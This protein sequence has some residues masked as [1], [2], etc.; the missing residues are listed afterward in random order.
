MYRR[1][2]DHGWSADPLEFGYAYQ[3]LHDAEA[4]AT[5]PAIATRV[6]AIA[7][8]IDYLRLLYEYNNAPAAMKDAALDVLLTHV[9]RLAP[10]GMVHAYRIW[11]LLYRNASA[12]MQ[13]RW[14][15]GSPTSH[16]A[17]WDQV[18][19]MG[20]ITS[21][22]MHEQV[23]AG[24][25]AYPSLGLSPASSPFVGPLVPLQ[26]PPPST[27]VDTTD[28]G[29]SNEYADEYVFYPTAGTQLTFTVEIT[30]RGYPIPNSGAHIT[31]PGGT[32][33]LTQH[34]AVPTNG[35]MMYPINFTP[36]QTGAYHRRYDAAYVEDHIVHYPQSL[37]FVHVLP[38]QFSW[39]VDFRKDYF[40]VPRGTA[41]FGFLTTSTI[42]PL[43]QLP[44]GTQ[45][46][47][48]WHGPIA[49]IDVPPGQDH[50]VWSITGYN[51][52]MEFENIPNYVAYR[53]EQLLVPSDSL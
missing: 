27:M 24:V 2:W 14:D 26:T 10:T 48:A 49:V 6:T 22:E 9:W 50:A 47:V 31:D 53:P 38:D 33:V 51:G 20:P 23:E 32:I 29:Y 34:F 12:A 11:Q 7:G 30:G 8:Y 42:Q 46:T 37:P 5:D 18:T 36:S 40:W 28:M 44:D 15:N 45:A 41:R 19:A 13:A 43:F 4:L 52:L 16:S 39:Y 3:A 25:A 35:T 1:F 21:A 17:G